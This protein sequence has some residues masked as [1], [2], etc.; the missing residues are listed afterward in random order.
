MDIK[1]V[2]ETI[3][4]KNNS[5]IFDFEDI[6]GVNQC[7]STLG[8]LIYIG[9]GGLSVCFSRGLKE[10]VKCCKKRKTSITMSK[11]QFLSNAQNLIEYNMPILAPIEVLYENN[12]WLIYTQPL[13][14]V[15]MP[16]EITPR[17]CCDVLSF[18]SQMIKVNTRISD[19]F[20]RNFGIY[21]N[22]LCLFDYHE[23]DTFESS[24]NFMISNLYSLFTILGKNLG[25]PVLDIAI[26]NIAAVVKDNFGESRF[27]EP[28][29][30]F[31]SLMHSKE[32]SKSL[33]FLE[34]GKKI[35]KRL[36]SKKYTKYQHVTIDEEGSLELSSH[37][38]VKYELA[39][40]FIKDKDILTILDARSCIGGI[41]LKLA[42]TFPNIKVTLS[43]S[44]TDELDK[45]K[46]IAGNCMIYNASFL[47][48]HIKDTKLPAK[49]DLV[50]YYSLF[51]H[52]LKTQSIDC[53]IRMVKSQVSKFCI[54]EVPMKGDALLEKVMKNSP[55]TEHFRCLTSPD[56]FR[57]NLIINRIKVN[58]CVKVD[59]GSNRLIR[60]AYICSF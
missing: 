49:Y 19:I 22:K 54:I 12:S 5:Q 2:I 33:E 21:Q 9:H 13:C 43:N 8:P 38:L 60:Y 6:S 34:M 11:D 53:I 45:T 48:E 10:V 46:K 30:K 26:T 47:N 20:Y 3:N 14:K 1:S 25:W 15:L 37:T 24:S 35:L 27:P 41:G 55:N 39:A 51:H 16:E 40:S 32:Y 58:K 29:V 52:L 23:V 17:L 50:L 59:Y 18:V 56:V 36:I 57:Y 44:D 42:Q 28:I 31:L 4:T 7:L